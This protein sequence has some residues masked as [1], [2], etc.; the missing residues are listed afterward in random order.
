MATFNL[1]GSTS[2]KMG[3]GQNDESGSSNTVIGQGYPVPLPGRPYS[4]VN[5]LTFPPQFVTHTFPTGTFAKSEVHSIT[6]SN[7]ISTFVRVPGI[8][9]KFLGR[10]LSGASSLW[11][12]SWPFNK[13]AETGR[14]NKTPKKTKHP[15]KIIDCGTVQYVKP[16]RYFMYFT[17][18]I[19]VAINN[20]IRKMS[21]T[22][23]PFT[24]SQDNSVLRAKGL[25][26]SNSLTLSDSGDSSKSKGGLSLAVFSQTGGLGI[27][28]NV[29]ASHYFLMASGGYGIK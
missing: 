6:L 23:T 28:K 1:S 27:N 8:L 4:R 25:S 13:A 11:L 12:A 22:N 17:H 18:A 3:Q 20:T 29:S 15:F 9:G 21:L 5:D 2:M 10:A 16:N 26:G 7:N 19:T 14:L 24:I